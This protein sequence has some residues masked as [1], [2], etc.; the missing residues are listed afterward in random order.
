MHKARASP[1]VWRSPPML[2]AASAKAHPNVRTLHVDLDALEGEFI[3]AAGPYSERKGITYDAWRAAGV[4]PRVLR[5][6]GLSRGLKGPF[7][8]SVA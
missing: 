6:A 2:R 5:A 4:E 7:T 8:R 1:P 3:R